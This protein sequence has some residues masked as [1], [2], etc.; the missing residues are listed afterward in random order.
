VVVPVRDRRVLLRE[1]LSA[2]AAQT[3]ANYEVVVVDDAST[4]GSHEEAERAAREGQ[5]VRL[6]RLERPGGAVHAR[7]A[8]AAAARG[9]VLAFTDSDCRPEPGWLAAL[10]GAFE[11][12]NDVVQGATRPMRAVGP[13]ERSVW[14]ETDDGLY[15]TCN[16]AYTR[17][18]YE[19]AG[20]YREDV[21]ELLGFRLGAKARG[22]GFGEDSLLAWRVRRSGR[23]AFEPTAVVRHAVFAFEPRSAFSRAWQAGAFPALVREIP[24]LRGTLLH[25]NVLLGRRAQVWLLAAAGLAVLRRPGA[26]F[27]ALL[28]WVRH[29][30]R[31]VARDDR[32]WPARLGVVLAREVVLEAAVVAGAVRSRTLVL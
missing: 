7:V 17:A 18:A 6:V 11:A 27:I 21:P 30:A 32:R 1:L 13:L 3:Y 20:G 12:G 14:G 22:L 23:A 5:P 10:V 31:A 28:P 29:H 26:A 24:E 16:V 4:D 2:L 15:A 9:D 8:G 19:A 25:R